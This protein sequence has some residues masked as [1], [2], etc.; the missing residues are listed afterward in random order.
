MVRE[1]AKRQND[2]AH[3]ETEPR[4][5][6]AG[7]LTP[8]RQHVTIT[9]R[10]PLIEHLSVN[11]VRRLTIMVSPAGFGK[12]TL[13]T[14][15]AAHVRNRPGTLTS[16]LSLDEEDNEPG[17][18]LA[19]LIL[20]LSR[21]GVNLDRLGVSERNPSIDTN[22]QG[23]VAKLILAVNRQPDKVLIILD[24]YHRLRSPAVDVI[25]ETLIDRGG[26]Q[27]HFAIA[28]RKRPTFQVSA[29]NA[30]GQVNYLDASDLALSEAEAQTVLGPAVTRSD[31]ALVHART[32]G[33]AVAL[34]LARLWLERGKRTPDRLKDFSGRTTEMAEYLV[35]QVVNDLPEDLRAFVLETSILDRL[36][37][38]L[39]NA[40]RLK[41]DSSMLLERLE[42]FNALIVSLDEERHWYRYHHLFAEFLVQRLYRT[43]GAVASDLHRRAAH[44]LA[45]N[46]DLIPAIDHALAAEDQ[47]LAIHIV[48]EG[49]GWEL[50]LSRGIGYSRNVLKKFSYLTIRNELTLQLM[51]AYLDAK[52]GHQDKAME[53]LRLAEFSAP[54]FNAEQRRDFF[55]ISSLVRC[56][57]DE[58]DAPDFVS[59]IEAGLAQ[60]PPDDHLGRATVGATVVVAAIGWGNIRLATS[61]SIAAAKEMQS[62]NSKLGANYMLLHLGNCR[63]LSGQLREAQ[64]L[65]GSALS[66][67]EE[68]FGTESSLRG[69]AGC[70]LAYSLYL[71]NQL[72]DADALIE[73]SLDTIQTIDGWFDVYAAAYEILVRRTMQEKGLDAAMSM[74]DDATLA[75]RERNFVR[76]TALASA[77]RVEIL[78]ASGHLAEAKREAGAANLEA[79]TLRESLPSF[80]WRMRAASAMAMARVS[81]ANGASAQ[82]WHILHQVSDDFFRVGIN[83]PARRM[84]AMGLIALREHPDD[85]RM[86]RDLGECIDFVAKEGGARILLNGGAGMESVL[87]N[88]LKSIGRSAVNRREVLT[89]LL[90]D[91]RKEQSRPLDEFSASEL[92]VLR[93]LRLGR[94]N[95]VIA[96]TLD[97]SENTV[98]FHLK[99]I[100][101]KLNVDSRAAAIAAAINRNLLDA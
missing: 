23:V 63:L 61:A 9:Q 62:A 17:R 74:L 34:Q 25:V 94:P 81:F 55:V 56:Y 28:G 75:G 22:I 52:L 99:H 57:L 13:L 31:L 73:R 30:R 7:K 95:K 87:Q 42:N 6:L 49:G 41:S 21:A 4:W 83:L 27:I 96:R 11:S 29:L 58:M 97:V 53:M 36:N 3:E 32:E 84:Q 37:P 76:L 50:V 91:L 19:Y 40:V 20:S 38:D 82:A 16:W 12:T 39:A 101:R 64:R 70:F 54:D 59:S 86:L 35:E 45:A 8:P 47:D 71:D 33:W 77:W 24:D 15:W 14:Q 93:E 69:I 60:L 51:Q 90:G 85:E 89:T 48:R 65:L 67:A 2:S 68:N 43:T 66:E 44:W 46:D 26:D 1:A 78:A 88:A 18:F 92:N 79:I 72:A 98:K 100:Y 80:E 10:A 5:L